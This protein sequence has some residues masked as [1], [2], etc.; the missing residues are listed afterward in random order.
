MMLNG[1]K[2]TWL[3]AARGW[4]LEETAER[5]RDQGAKQV[6]YQHIQQLEQFPKR[7]PRFLLELAAAFGMTAEE[8]R[9]WTPPV[10]GSGGAANMARE[11]APAYAGGDLARDIREL[12]LALVVMGDWIRTTRPIEAPLLEAELRKAAKRLGSGPRDSPLQMVI[13]S[14]AGSAGHATPESEPRSN[15]A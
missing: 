10:E 2:V 9:R 12:S 6:K 8:F 1:E 13:D 7:S 4:T 5:V 11:A 14:V 15:R 3:R